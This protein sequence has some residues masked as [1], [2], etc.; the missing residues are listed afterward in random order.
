MINAPSWFGS[1]DPSGR[2]AN[3]AQRGT[4]EV[5]GNSRDA[6]E[7]I[8]AN[9]LAANEITE[10]TIPDA[11][12]LPAADALEP[13]ELLAD[14]PDI[15]GDPDVGGDTVR[16]TSQW[17]EEWRRQLT[18]IF[19]VDMSPTA[20]AMNNDYVANVF[21]AHSIPLAAP[22]VADQELM[23]FVQESRMSEVAE[24]PEQQDALMYLVHADSQS[25]D[26]LVQTF[27]DDFAN[28]PQMRTDI[29]YDAPANQL[30]KRI[31]ESSG[32]RLAVHEAFATPVSDEQGPSPSPFSGIAPQ[33]K[34]VASSSRGPNAQPAGA[35]LAGVGG[36]GKS[37]VLLFV[38]T[39]K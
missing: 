32:G 3:V 5:P 6:I 7:E 9:Q 15:S 13:S 27:L 8:A 33:G 16:L 19:V 22:V 26:H 24:Q 18:I 1:N 14:A 29:A 10:N 2:D 23:A 20:E 38:R 11:E 37:T 12:D 21:A 17:M 35:N 30:V 25:V 39:P 31:V 4:P 34:L 36:A 28:V